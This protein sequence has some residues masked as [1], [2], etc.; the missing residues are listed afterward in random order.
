VL[1]VAVILAANV[2]ADFLAGSKV[3]N[4]VDGPG[5][6]ERSRILDGDVHLEVR[7]IR[8]AVALDQMQLL[9]VRVD[10]EPAFVVHSHR[11]DHER[12]SLPAADG[13]AHPGWVQILRVA[14]AVQKNLT[15]GHHVL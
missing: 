14:A 9:R 5:L 1:S 12:V 11:I 6:R 4:A 15:D 2:F 7:E 3:P 13:V 8:P 10:V